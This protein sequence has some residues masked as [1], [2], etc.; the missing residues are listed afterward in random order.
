MLDPNS[1][2]MRGGSDGLQAIKGGAEARG[3]ERLVQV[4]GRARQGGRAQRASAKMTQMALPDPRSRRLAHMRPATGSNPRGVL[5]PGTRSTRSTVIQLHN[6]IDTAR[7]ASSQPLVARCGLRRG[8]SVWLRTRRGSTWPPAAVWQVRAGCRMRPCCSASDVY[9]TLTSTLTWRPSLPP[10]IF[11]S[12]PPSSRVLHA[13][14][15]PYFCLR[16]PCHGRLIRG[17]CIP[18]PDETAEHRRVQ[19]V[20]LSAP[21]LL[22]FNGQ[23]L[24]SRQPPPC[25]CR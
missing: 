20:L 16:S 11:S 4:S 10:I 8:R 15:S 6:V 12:F 17:L 19:S 1:A 5:I 3:D 23:R 22:V 24:S 25:H 18:I 2:Y 7:A 21:L 13:G 14:A 9:V